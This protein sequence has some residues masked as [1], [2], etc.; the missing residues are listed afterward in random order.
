MTELDMFLPPNGRLILVSIGYE[1]VGLGCLRKIGD[2]L[3]EIKRMYVRPQFRGRGIG[4]DLLEH[5]FRQAKMMG[6]RRLRLDS[7]R[8]MHIAHSLYRSCGFKEIDPY[9]ESEI[10]EEL[11]EY[12]V[13][14]ELN[15]EGMI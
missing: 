12:W 10:P 15:L 4:R 2:G 3:A 5:L 6:F 11:R 14:M 8:F 1:T 9:P 13:F 7:T